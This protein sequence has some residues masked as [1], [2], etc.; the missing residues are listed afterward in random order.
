MQKTSTITMPHNIFYFVGIAGSGMSS[1]ARVLL[2]LGYTVYGWDDAPDEA[3]QSMLIEAGAQCIPWD[4]AQ[5]VECV[6][7]STAVTSHHPAIQWAQK[8]NIPLYHRSDILAQLTHAVPTIAVC[9][10]HGKTTTTSMVHHILSQ[11]H[12]PH[13]TILG[14]IL[15]G[16]L[17]GDIDD[18]PQWL[19]IEACESDRS[20]LKYHAQYVILTNISCD[21]LE[22]YDDSVDNLITC[23]AQWFNTIKPQLVLPFKHAYIDQ[24]IQQLHIPYV[25]VGHMCQDYTLSYQPQGLESSITL[26]HNGQHRSFHVPAPGEFNAMNA[27]MALV[28]VDLMGCVIWSHPT[29]LEGYRRIGRRFDY[30]KLQSSQQHDIHWI[31][32]YGHHPYEIETMIHTLRTLW[33]DFPIRMVFEPHRYTRSSMHFDDFCKVL[34]RVDELYV[35]PIYAAAEQPIKGITSDAMVERIAQVTHKAMTP[36]YLQSH[37]NVWS[38][39]RGVVIFQ[40]AGTVHQHALEWLSRHNVM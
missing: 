32:D 33:P 22:Y 4:A 40:G 19:V 7:Y 15:N 10:S 6:V 38:V 26:E 13:V 28:I 9:G 39:S 5:N 24:M 35:L 25:Q 2:R 30:Q 8:A 36:E 31:S 21:H 18:A 20:F 23:F 1:I 16:G 11:L 17:G 12:I 27:A 34:S 37:I 29:V 3:V 14:G